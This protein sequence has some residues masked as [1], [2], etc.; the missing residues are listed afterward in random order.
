[1]LSITQST[2]TPTPDSCAVSFVQLSKWP[3]AQPAY[4]HSAFQTTAERSE[5]RPQYRPPLCCLLPPALS[6]SSVLLLAGVVRP[7][8]SPV[9]ML[10]A[11][12]T[13]VLSDC[14]V[15]SMCCPSSATAW[16]TATCSNQRCPLSLPC[17]LNRPS[18]VSLLLA[19]AT[20]VVSVWSVACCFYPFS[21]TARLFNVG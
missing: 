14:R 7:Q 2:P 6:S 17:C 9:S 13:A 20:A 15:A 10:H 11:V 3:F 1:M 19:D 16:L 21:A 12:A 18:S 8:P 5:L 4:V